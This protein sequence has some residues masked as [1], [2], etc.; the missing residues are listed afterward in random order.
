MDGWMDR[1]I[2]GWM[3]T[4]IDE[5]IHGLASSSWPGGAA[6]YVVCYGCVFLSP[7]ARWHLETSSGR[8]SKRVLGAEH[9]SVA[10]VIVYYVLS[11]RRQPTSVFQQGRVT[12]PIDELE[13]RPRQRSHDPSVGPKRSQVAFSKLCRQRRRSC[14]NAVYVP[15]RILAC[16]RT[17]FGRRVNEVHPASDSLPRPP[18]PRGTE[19]GRGSVFMS[20]SLQF[21]FPPQHYR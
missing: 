12:R 14:C 2:D 16:C 17:G 8:G 11:C 19:P 13:Q 4:W 20:S 7:P 10:F 5:W 18:P 21:D 1:R 15:H 9:K 3:D 6:G